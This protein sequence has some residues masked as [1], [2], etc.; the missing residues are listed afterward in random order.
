M[1]DPFNSTWAPAPYGYH[2]GSWWVS[3]SSQPTYQPLYNLQIEYYP[4]LPQSAS[5]RNVDLTSYQLANSSSVITGF[6]YDYYHYND[7]VSD[8]V[9]DFVGTGTLAA[10]NNT[11]EL[12][13]WGYDTDGE[14][15]MVL[16]ETPVAFNSAPSDID[17]LSR[18]KGGPTA[19]T[20]RALLE[21]LKELEIAELTMLVAEMV[22]LPVDDRRDGLGPA[23]CDQACMNNE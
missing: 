7:T 8:W 11:W 20:R 16:Y 5:F 13:A 6:G 19:D 22:E 18:V 1:E 12:L 9:Y 2:F 15:Y 17:I 14:P 21:G 23:L 4:V 10:F 3:H